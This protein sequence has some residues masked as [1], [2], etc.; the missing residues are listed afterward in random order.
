MDVT[1]NNTNV[2]KATKLCFTEETMSDNKKNNQTKSCKDNCPESKVNQKKNDNSYSDC[3][4]KNSK[5]EDSR[6]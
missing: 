1:G 3:K 5:K 6:S 2:A 4:E